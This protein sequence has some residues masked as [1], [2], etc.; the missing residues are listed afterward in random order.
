MEF[1][2]F[3]SQLE[4]AGQLVRISEPVG[5]EYD[6]GA[7]CRQLSDVDG[8]AVILEKVDDMPHPLAMNLYGTRGRLAAGLGVEE[9]DLLPF[10][11]S[12][13]GERIETVPYQGNRAPCQEVVIPE[14]Q[15]DVSAWPFPLWNSG[16]GGRYITAGLVIAHHPEF[17]WNIAHHR[18]Q[19]YNAREIGMCMAPDHHLRLATDAAREAGEKVEAAIVVGV[20]PSIT[21]AS[22]SDFAFGDYELTVAGALEGRPIEVVKCRTVDVEVPADSEMVIEGYYDGEVRREGPFVEFTGYQTEVIQSPVFRVTAITHRTNPIVHGIYAGK[23]PCETNTLWRELEEAVALRTLRARFPQLVAVHRPPGIGRDFTGFLQVD[24]TLKKPGLV[25]TLMLATAAAMPRLKYVVAVDDDIDIYDLTEVMWAV[26]TRCNPQ[27]D[28]SMVPGTMTSWLDPSSR[29]LT[30]KLMIDATK[31]GD[32]TGTIPTYPDE[33]MMRARQI[34][35]Q[36]IKPAGGWGA[37]DSRP[38]ERIDPRGNSRDEGPR[39]NGDE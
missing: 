12:K 2:E 20:R 14:D 22:S 3:L 7:L 37:I 25:P 18:G 24:L 16:D 27:N 8:P 32:F 5:I 38:M 19:I 31:K 36:M 11:S 4:D 30:G 13:I 21:I 28:I 34:L 35:E 10:V 17:G 15:A 39:G 29:G 6:A 23:P 33:A 1:R 26:S 9:T